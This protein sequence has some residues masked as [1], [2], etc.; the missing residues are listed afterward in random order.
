[1]ANKGTIFLDEIGDLDP[2]CQVKLLRV[3]TV[4]YTHL[5]VYKR[6]SKDFA[7]HLMK[8]SVNQL[9][10]GNLFILKV[11]DYEDIRSRK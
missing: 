1:M 7:E 2:S 10:V 11:H 6:Q 5:D 3:L 8:L 4:S 9:S